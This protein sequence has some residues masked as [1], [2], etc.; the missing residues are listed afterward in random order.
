[1]DLDGDGTI[2]YDEMLNAA[3]FRRVCAKEERL[4]RAFQK[5]DVNHD[6]SITVDELRQ[7]LGSN[8]DKDTEELMKDADINHDGVVDYSEFLRLFDQELVDALHD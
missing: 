7:A 2:N 6:G 5:L 8:N 1:M 3:I 4:W